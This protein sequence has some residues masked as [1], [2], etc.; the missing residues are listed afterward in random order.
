MAR[1]GHCAPGLKRCAMLLSM[2]PRRSWRSRLTSFGCVESVGTG[3]AEMPKG[4]IQR[5]WGN[6]AMIQDLL[7]LCCGPRTVTRLKVR[8]GSHIGRKER[9]IVHVAKSEFIT[10]R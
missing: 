5:D 1:T 9:R 10:L 2:S 6:S 8:L 3:E 4:V 7:E